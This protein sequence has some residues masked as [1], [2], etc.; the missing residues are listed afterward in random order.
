MLER[1][2]TTL[3]HDQRVRPDAFAFCP[4]TGVNLIKSRRHI[5]QRYL[6][7]IRLGDKEIT[8][9]WPC[10]EGMTDEQAIH[11]AQQELNAHIAQDSAIP[12]WQRQPL[13][14]VQKINNAIRR[15]ESV[16]WGED[17]H[18]LYK[19]L[20]SRRRQSQFQVQLALDHHWYN[21]HINQIFRVKP[22]SSRPR[23]SSHGEET[24]S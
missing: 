14:T 18:V 12:Q 9:Q 3:F 6:L 16:Y 15:D 22:S 4:N 2:R 10:D 1:T 17:P 5:P 20:L 8:L 19:I 11:L 23:T 24:I 13:P 21:A 7:I